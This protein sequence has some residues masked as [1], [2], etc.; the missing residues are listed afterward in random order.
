MKKM[1]EYYKNCVLEMDMK[2]VALFKLCLISFGMMLGISLP[3]T[4]KKPIFWI[5][6]VLFIGTAI[7]L[8]AGLFGF[9]CPFCPNDE[10]DFDYDDEYDEYD[11]MYDEYFDDE[12][13]DDY[14]EDSEGFVMKIVAEEE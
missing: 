13:D 11:E 7:S 14:N 10:D 9:E 4:K 8:F 6:L 2:D 12:D 1:V 3:C 5:S